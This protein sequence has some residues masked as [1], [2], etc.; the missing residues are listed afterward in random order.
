MVLSYST[1]VN[2]RLFNQSILVNLMVIRCWYFSQLIFTSV[3]NL[4]IEY[5][6]CLSI[7]LYQIDH[8]HYIFFY[9]SF[10]IKVE[11]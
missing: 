9:I 6:L 10:Y 5:N 8:F 3:Y 11:L 2:D 7:K 4:I 1:L